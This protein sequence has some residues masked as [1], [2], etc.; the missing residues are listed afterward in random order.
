MMCAGACY[1]AG[2]YF[3]LLRDKS[4]NS[5]NVLIVNHVHLFHAEGTDLSLQES[6]PVLLRLRSARGG[7]PA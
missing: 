5:F 7:F 4:A 2:Q 3:P 6:F 1:T